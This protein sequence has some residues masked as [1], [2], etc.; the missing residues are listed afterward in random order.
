MEKQ[1][2]RRGVLWEGCFSDGCYV[3]PPSITHIDQCCFRAYSDM[4]TVE[5]PDSLV[6]IGS[7]AFSCCANLAHISLPPSLEEIGDYAF[8]SNRFTEVT[9]P[10]SRET[11]SLLLLL[12]FRHAAQGDHRRGNGV[13]R[14]SD[15]RRLSRLERGTNSHLRTCHCRKRFREMPAPE[16]HR[17]CR[18]LRR[19][20]CQT[21]RHSDS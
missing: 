1:V 4:Q 9:V 19:Q 14:G 5:L 6:S 12:C 2:L 11:Y 3:I 10:G 21:A 7:E 15:F 18:F 13:Y 20:L 16:H 17:P 8:S